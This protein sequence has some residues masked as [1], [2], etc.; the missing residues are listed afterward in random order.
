MKMK[1]SSHC[2]R[3]LLFSGA[4]CAALEA[5]AAP[6]AEETNAPVYHVVIDGKAHVLRGGRTARITLSD[7]REIRIAV[8]LNR[9]Q[10]YR[11]AEL[12]FEYD[13]GLSLKDDQDVSER[14][15]TLLHATGCGLVITDQ[16][17][18]KDV[19][20][21]KLLLG[22]VDQMLSRAKRGVAKNISKSTM[23]PVSFAHAKGVT[24]K[25]THVDED[26]DTQTRY[27]YVL[28]CGNRLASVVGFHDQ[29]CR[30]AYLR[31]QKATLES[32]QEGGRHA[33]KTGAA[34]GSQPVRAGTNST[35]SSAGSRR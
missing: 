15:I 8:D 3:M 17:L 21:R 26:G 5:P 33:N 35:S 4:L 23:E 18:A 10:P 6:G 22:L 16:G 28:Q 9:V 27:Y 30:E 14:T 25:S 29:D 2:G 20:Q 12:E 13:A 11:T 32:L 19:N 34:N 7:G 1:T 31:M 24:T